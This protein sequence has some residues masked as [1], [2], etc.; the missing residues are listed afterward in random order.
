MGGSFWCVLVVKFDA[1]SNLEPSWAQ[2]VRKVWK[3]MPKWSPTAAFGSPLELW[4]ACSGGLGD[5]LG[6]TF[7]SA[8]VV[9][10]D[11]CLRSVI[12]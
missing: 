12:L 7:G 5:G 2:V 6:V 4:R 3:M 11:M 1:R 8:G 9:F 10:D